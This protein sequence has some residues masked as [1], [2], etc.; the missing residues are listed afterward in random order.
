MR[1][2]MKIPIPGKIESPL[3]RDSGFDA[4]WKSL[5]VGLGALSVHSNDRDIDRIDYA[6][7][8]I[9]DLALMFELARK[10]HEW[11]GV[12]PEFLPEV[13]PKSYFG[14]R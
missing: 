8:E 7:F 14:H 10:V 9:G 11:L 12:K 5:L 4:R 13:I 3:R 2:L 1:V 6:V